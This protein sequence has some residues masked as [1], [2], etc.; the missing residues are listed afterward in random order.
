MHFTFT[1]WRENLMH[2]PS[3]I[4]VQLLQLSDRETPV[5]SHT[6]VTD[7]ARHPRLSLK[8]ISHP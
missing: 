1:T 8:Q 2:V 6:E 3:V 7:E 4:E 5:L